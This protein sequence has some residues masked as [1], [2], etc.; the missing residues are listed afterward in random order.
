MRF[1]NLDINGDWC[2]G[3]GRNSYLSGNQA[4]MLNIKTRLLEFLGDCFWDTEKGIDW[5]VL[6]GGKDLKSIIAS[7]QR[8][9]LRSANVKRIVELDYTLTNR[10][11]YVKVSVEFADGEI[12]TDT[13]EVLN[14]Q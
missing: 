14:A 3:K 11:L 13:V 10:K 4:L 1:R 5:W 7:I 6:L 12:L 9:I 2:F 8:V